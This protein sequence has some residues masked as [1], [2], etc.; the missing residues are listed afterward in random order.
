MTNL[1]VMLLFLSK[2]RLSRY[3]TPILFVID[4]LVLNGAYV[5]SVWVKYNSLDE[6]WNPEIKSFFLLSNSVWLM[7]V[8]YHN[9]YKLERVE[10]IFKSLNRLFLLLFLHAGM[11]ILLLL[12]FEFPTIS[13]WR[14][15]YFYVLF[16][17]GLFFYQYAFLKT[18]KLI[19]KKG[20]N[21]R[22]VVIF[23]SNR[24]GNELAAALGKDASLGYQVAG[25]FDTRKSKV[26][27]PA[28]FFGGVS[29]LTNYLEVEK[30]DELYVCKEQV[31]SELMSTLIALCEKYMVRIKFVPNFQQFT[32]SKKIDV[33]FY[34][35]IPV[36]KIRSEPL[37]NPFRQAFK[38]LFDIV[39][40]L[41]V[42][43][44]VFPWLFP[45][46]WVAT[47][48]SS[49]GPIFFKQKRSGEGNLPF[50]CL[51]FRTMRV[52]DL[53]DVHQAQEKDPRITKVGAFLRKT[54]LDEFPQFLNVLAGSMS[55]VGPRPH[56]L[57]HTEQY[58]ALLSNYLVR[59]Y[60]KP[61]ITGWAQVS[62]YRGETK[63]LIDMKKRVEYDIYYIE[64]WN[65]LLDLKIIGLTLKNMLVGEEKAR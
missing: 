65:F 45:L 32:Q 30:A 20:F 27:L 29:Q 50:T 54:N 17:G 40:S 16:S 5:L 25:F 43:L 23:G 62:G 63:E 38:R 37:E 48:A 60:S 26:P 52:N 19:R 49:P 9:A 12:V 21:F 10:P 1:F 24:F 11:M 46:I 51:K 34:D 41:A 42:I 47:K 14:I 44:L 28:P 2:L 3:F 36:I 33:N 61:G 39:F 4:V 15:F 56:M 53:A 55:V 6:L 64:N 57:K 13:R 8:I 7:L 18:I 58:S 35:A 22:K 59:H 31:S